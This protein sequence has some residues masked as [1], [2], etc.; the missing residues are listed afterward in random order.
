[1]SFCRFLTSS[2]TPHAFNGLPSFPYYFV[3]E[4]KA[5][6]AP[7]AEYQYL[8]I[9]EAHTDSLIEVMRYWPDATNIERVFRSEIK[10]PNPK[11]KSKWVWLTEFHEAP[12]DRILI[13]IDDISRIKHHPNGASIVF[14][15]G[16][17]VTVKETP[18][19]IFNMMEYGQ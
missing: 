10:S 3:G 2:I 18:F 9:V 11:P 13:N 14:S 6:S 4:R 8:S 19:D 1:M 16:E 17:F 12:N 7:D 5:A 15:D